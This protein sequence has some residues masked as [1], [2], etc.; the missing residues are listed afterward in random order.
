MPNPT[1]KYKLTFNGH[2]LPGYAQ[3]E[4]LPIVN[5]DPRV[6]IINRDGGRLIDNNSD[7]RS[8]SFSFDILTRLDN[9]N[10][11]IAHLGDCLEQYRDAARY[12]TRVSSA[13]TLFLGDTSHYLIAKYSKMTSPLAAPDSRRIKYSVDFI[14]YPWFYGPTIFANQAVS[15]PTSATLNMPDTRRT[16]PTIGIPSGITAMTVSHTSSG[17]GF[18]FSGSHSV[19]LTVDCGALT[20]KSLD[21]A[22]HVAKIVSGPD[23]GIFHVGSGSCVLDITGVQGSGTL[24]LSMTP[25]LER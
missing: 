8:I 20:V 1:A 22:N 24:N 12:I 19:Y 18:T 13:S 16:Y 7:F 2:Q 23:F 6:S 11:G 4:E 9:N 3:S 21:G 14:A 25:R 5:R 10:T 15:G 17:K